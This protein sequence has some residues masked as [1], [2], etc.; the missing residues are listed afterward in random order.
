MGLTD[1]GKGET[2]QRLTITLGPG[3]RE[4]LE[5]IAARNHATLA[6]V[7]RY[8][9]TEFIESH[10]CS[11]LPLLFPTAAGPEDPESQEK[12]STAC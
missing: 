8:A 1:T 10:E 6:F 12:Q 2:Q 7:V 9:L 3:Q 11:R 4:A 5:A